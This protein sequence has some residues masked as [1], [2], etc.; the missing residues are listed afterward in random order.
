MKK[1]LLGTL[2]IFNLLHIKSQI[3]NIQPKVYNLPCGINCTNFV[4]K[5]P[6]LRTT[7]DYVIRSTPY[8]PQAFT[9]ASGNELNSLYVDDKYSAAIA[10][11]F[12]CCMYGQAFTQFIVGSNGILSFDLSYAG[13]NN[14]YVVN[15]DI[16]FE[17]TFNCTTISSAHYPKYC[18][19]SPYHDI[20]PSITAISPGRKIE[21][22]VDGVAPFRKLVVNFYQIG[23]YGTGCASDPTKLC[24]SQIVLNE[25]TSEVYVYIAKKETCTSWQS[26][27]AILGIQKDA[28]LALPVPGHNANDPVWTESNTAYLFKPNGT[29]ALLQSVV[30]TK[31]DGTLVGN[32]IISPATNDSVTISYN[33]YCVSGSGPDTL[34]VKA[35]Y[36]G[37]DPAAPFQ[38]TDTIYVVK[39]PGDLLA[40][41]TTSP[42][43]CTASN[44][45]I[46]VDVTAGAGTAPYQYSINGGALQNSNTFTGLASGTYTI[47]VKDAGGTCTSTFTIF[48]GITNP[49]TL[50]AVTTLTSCPGVSNGSITVN[51]TNATN[52]IQYSINN[53]LF[54][55]S[56]VFTGLAAGT[57]SIKTLDGNGCQNLTFVTVND[58]TGIT[59]T[60]VQTPVT[61]SGA[62]NGILTITNPTGTGP[63]QYALDAGAY[64][65][66]N[67]FTG[68]TQGLHTVKVKDATGCIYTTTITV[69]IGTGITATVT[70]TPTTCAGVNNGIITITN[71]TGT[72]PHEYALDA[73]AYQSGN[74]FNGVATGVHTIKVRDAS[75]CVYTTTI[76][77]TAGAGITATVT[78]TPTTCAGVNNGIITITNPT[79]TG[80]H[81]YALDA[82]AYQSG[83]TFNGVATGVHTVKVKDATGCVFTTTINVTA[84]TGVTASGI[85][86]NAAC[87]GVNNGTITVN[88]STGQT[89][90]Q[91]AV[92]GGPNQSS[93]Q[94]TGLAPATYT[95]LV[96]DAF[97]CTTS[98]PL[99]VA[100]GTGFTATN[101]TTPTSCTGINN[102]SITLTPTGGATPYTYSLD[103]GA[104]QNANIFSN[105]S[106]G[107]HTVLITDNLGCTNT[108]LV[109]VIAGTVFTL[110][111]SSTVA[112]CLT[113]LN[114]TISILVNGGN[115][116]YSYV[117]DGG[118]PQNNGNF[119][120][121]SAGSHTVVV[122]DNSGCTNAISLTVGTGSG[123]N[124][125][126]ITSPTTC[127]GAMNGTITITASS[128]TAPYQYQLNS[129]PFQNGNTFNGLA[130]GL[131][132]IN[133]KDFYNCSFT[134]SATV[135]QG[136]NL[137]A[138]TIV[139]D[140]LCNGGNSGSI[141]VN[142]TNGNPAYQYSLNGGAFQNS[143][144][145][146]NLTAGNYT[147][148]LQDGNNCTG[149]VTVTIAAPALLTLNVT[150]TAVLCN[151][152]QEMAEPEI[153]AIL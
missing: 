144:I 101:T 129:G 43:T 26:G 82:G 17:G 61:C 24:T 116:P 16:P 56:N 105:V 4:F 147:I 139:A 12:S 120:N 50:S 115:S 66:G 49:V 23:L 79:G 104:T 48:V 113:A 118:T 103:G 93:N 7:E 19:M 97:G 53:G 127:N 62:N 44:G 121:V 150:N 100:A 41:G 5:V 132:T 95:I 107:P 84:G 125:T 55:S 126:A 122:T 13:C 86:T 71:P 83:N 37:C 1:F 119:N 28:T 68:V 77:V 33:N 3:L 52:P 75:N 20:D 72:G 111:Q 85:V 153:T 46:L 31:K 9:S 35:N 135:A 42:A 34:V 65:G 45:S 91:Y 69:A 32:G 40:T 136:T 141:T 94:F 128:G 151:G 149:S 140:V 27:R 30:I 8:V 59:A 102:G 67:V 137:S 10:L 47:F 110:S 2:F 131:Y 54:Q 87:S 138:T 74:T 98:F 124:A 109:T 114:G 88:T 106:A 130:A 21:W 145:F 78:Q 36:I 6:D 11:P 152:Q 117:L 57:Y 99:T 58:G 134:F 25:S 64:Q 51:A 15:Q 63:Y 80:P 29:T 60:V 73:G 148:S 14:A 112:T 96:T 108:Q 143:N 133:V 81:E 38:L 89:P 123:I 18:V 92:N 76:N 39:N 22:R 142:N 70:Q 146:N 90:F